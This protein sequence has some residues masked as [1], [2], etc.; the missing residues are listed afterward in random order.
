MD[1]L[2]LVLTSEE[3]PSLTDII[4]FSSREANGEYRPRLEVTYSTMTMT[5]APPNGRNKAGSH[6]GDK[7]P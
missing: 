2:T 6:S 4:K 3:K 7:H 1:R 5:T